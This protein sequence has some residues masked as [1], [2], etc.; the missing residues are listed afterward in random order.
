ML[1]YEQNGNK[2]STL[3]INL[4]GV[5]TIGAII[6]IIWTSPIFANTANYK[7]ILGL[8]LCMVLYG[9]LSLVFMRELKMK[10]ST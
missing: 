8:Y 3:F 4:I 1:S 10:K 5:T 2:K 6:S 9:F 7:Y